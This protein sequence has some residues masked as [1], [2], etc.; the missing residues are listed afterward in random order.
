[1]EVVAGAWW[2]Q[3]WEGGAEHLGGEC[4]REGRDELQN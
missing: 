1:M 4:E 2:W 3:P